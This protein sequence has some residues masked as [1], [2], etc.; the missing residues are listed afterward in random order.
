MS[1]NSLGYFNLD[2]Q[3][4]TDAEKFVM[5]AFNIEY[6]LTNIYEALDYAQKLKSQ[7]RTFC[8]KYVPLEKGLY[9]KIYDQNELVDLKFISTFV[10]NPYTYD[11]SQPINIFG[12]EVLVDEV[13]RSFIATVKGERFYD[14]LYAALEMAKEF[15]NNGRYYCY[16]MVTPSWFK[17][18]YKET[19]DGRLLILL[20]FNRKYVEDPLLE[21][22]HKLKSF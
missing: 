8:Y 2:L 17:K 11:F 1:Y 15:R 20:W 13:D 3:N 19:F 6:Y 16:R 4:L 21:I 18:Q 9:E 7:G 10:E 22:R 5:T 14:S 12:R